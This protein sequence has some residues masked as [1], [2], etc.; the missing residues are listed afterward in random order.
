MANDI[1]NVLGLDVSEVIRGV[2][3][4]QKAFEAYNKGQQSILTT[5]GVLNKATGS[6][7]SA[8]KKLTAQ[9][10]AAT[11][12][13]A[14][15]NRGQGKQGPAPGPGPGPGPGSTQGPMQTLNQTLIQITLNGNLAAT[16]ILN[17]NNAAKQT[18]AQGAKAIGGMTISWE[19]LTR[20][21]QTQLI[22][23]TLSQVRNLFRAAIQ[24]AIKFEQAVGRTQTI[25]D[26]AGF[27]QIA[28]AARNLSD[29]FNVGLIDS[30][31]ALN[32]ALQNG[33]AVQGDFAGSVNF[34]AEALRFARVTNSG[35]S[36]SVNL[37]SGA[38]KS[39]GLQASDAAEVAS[40]FF[41]AIDKGRIT[42]SELAGSFGQVGT[43]GKQVGISLKESLSLL[44]AITQNGLDTAQAFTQVRAI[45]TALTAPSPKLKEAF[46]AMGFTAA[47]TAIRSKGLLNVLKD[48]S[49]F[50]RGNPE[51]LAAMFR[52]VRGRGGV[53]NLANQ[54]F[55]TLIDH[56]ENI[57]S[58]SSNT[59]LEKFLQ[60]TNNEGEKLDATINK[61][62][63]TF[64]VD[65]GRELLGTVN[66][67]LDFT[68]GVE[69]VTFAVQNAGPAV[70]FAAGSMALFATGLTSVLGPVAGLVFALPTLYGLIKSVQKASEALHTQELAASFKIAEE[71]NKKVIAELE[72]RQAEERALQKQGFDD[73]IKLFADATKAFGAE[74]QKR[75][76]IAQ[77]TNTALV[78]SVNASVDQIVNKFEDLV[79][80]FRDASS[81]A[82][83]LRAKAAPALLDFTNQLKEAQFSRVTRGLNAVDKARR[84]LARPV[85]Q[86]DLLAAKDDPTK[87]ALERAK[88]QNA[89]AI[90]KENLGFAEASG[91][92]SL[93]KRAEFDLEK[94]LQN[95][96]KSEQDLVAAQ[97]A[98]I[99][100]LNKKA[101]SYAQILARAKQLQQ[102]IKD[103]AD[104]EFSSGKQ[105]SDAE[106][107]RRKALRD[108][109]FKEL[110]GLAGKIDPV[111]AK[112]L[113]LGDAFAAGLKQALS[114][115]KVGIDDKSVHNQLDSALAS[116]K[117]QVSTKVGIDVEFITPNAKTPD[118]VLRGLVDKAE[119]GLKLKQQ[120][121]KLNKQDAD[122]DAGVRQTRFAT[123]QVQLPSAQSIFDQAP[124]TLFAPGATANREGVEKIRQAIIDIQN[125]IVAI[126]KQPIISDKDIQSVETLI[127]DLPNVA[128]PNAAEAIFGPFTQPLKDLKPALEQLKA[129]QANPQA[130]AQQKAQLQAQLQQAQQ[131]KNA[132]LTPQTT[133]QPL[134]DA[135]K[136][137]LEGAQAV[138]SAAI[139]SQTLR[140]NAVAAGNALIS[141]AQAWVQA[142]QAQFATPQVQPKGSAF[143]NF[144]AAGGRGTDTI[145][146][147]LSKGETVVDARNSAKFFPEL[148]AIR[149]GFAP[150][151]RSQGG[152]VNVGDITVTVKGG[153]TSA[154]TANSIAAK[155]N[156]RI[157]RGSIKFRQ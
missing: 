56:L 114:Q 119:E 100:A 44:S 102:Q 13:Q 143:G 34:T 47:D 22:V 118:E 121:D 139:P 122:H 155:L 1:K 38:I 144:F 125:R 10:E 64:S 59:N 63:N 67:L 129:L 97:E 156:R 75:F 45:I 81:A 51:V 20:V 126:A 116:Y 92:I 76:S 83:D 106:K 154:E 146:A 132:L 135:G 96:L 50:S 24:D 103:N 42:A 65:L 87:L 4:A 91:D 25:A 117:Q 142:A 78:A 5:I 70:T 30:T 12:A 131:V 33:V 14:A 54:E 18:G 108:S 153:D 66:A 77:S 37:L 41:A 79:K 15:F 90:A 141:G 52:N 134:I 31:E 11:K 120:L 150:R 73:S 112:K 110:T 99:P 23:R 109:A 72:K 111:D 17:V 105:L 123:R 58:V 101:A 84:A 71:Q 60:A 74:Y 21:V 55:D 107:T 124:N 68:G 43:A 85:P 49:A 151:F 89:L 26:G 104:V 69:G 137:L 148:Q 128:G 152:N 95:Q 57:N 40:D 86:A 145:A 149:A 46:A 48:L 29:E 35:A 2:N 88:L 127:K 27:N 32:Q 130:N 82:V 6:Q 16:S 8:L 9:Y 93:I 7:I 53:L 133:S 61:L 62:K 113:G 3:E 94:S 36:E 98:E 138:G 115:L 28:G 147:M 157:R 39:Y 80:G 136:S 19:T 140:D